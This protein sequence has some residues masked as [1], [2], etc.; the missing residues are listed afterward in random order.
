MSYIVEQEIKGNIYL[1]EVTSYWDKAMKQSRQKRKYIGRK[2]QNKKK[3]FL[4]DAE[5]I[6]KKYGNVFLLQQITQKLGL[7]KILEQ[8]FPDD[9][10]DILSLSFFSICNNSALYTYPLWLDEH[11]LPDAKKLHSPDVSALCQ[12][13]GRKQKSVY[14][15]FNLW[16]A[17][18]QS[19]S[20]V[21]FD[22]TSISSYANDIDFIEWGYNRDH[23][24]L[25]QLNIGLFCSEDT[26]LPIYYHIYPG[27][28][29][30]VSTLKNGL[31]YLHSFGLNDIMLILDRGFCSKKNILQMNECDSMT[32]IQPMTFSMKKVSEIIRT[33]RKKLK[34]I[35]SAIKFK[36]EI[37]H[38][39]STDFTLENEIFTAHLFYNEKA[40][41]D[42]RHNLLSMLFDIENTFTKDIF[43]TQKE[44]MDYRNENIPEKYQDFF[45][46]NRSKKSIERNDRKLK[47]YLLRSGYFIFLS[48]N[49]KLNK[50]SIL[51]H[52]R[53]RDIVEKMF[54]IEKN[55]MDSKRLRCHGEA[56]ANGR[57]FIKFIA[58]ITYSYIMHNMKDKQLFN[59]YS[60]KELLAILSK[61]RQTFING[62]Q[63]IS[64][65]SKAQR[66]I[67]NEFDI[68]P[69]MISEHSY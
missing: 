6:H 67:L 55:H 39:V 22:I 36:E 3:K 32:F 11:Q 13:I 8:V 30:D 54:D 43:E 48:N 37:L 7:D 21:Y 49:K 26:E 46:Y 65:V 41:I 66:E 23:E 18:C 4:K 53:K 57:I 27:S 45:K 9:F 50:Y 1:Y 16:T 28:I 5:I 34:D 61:I 56:S 52:Y 19:Y 63:I 20:S 59:K 42:Q 47:S 25:P 68:T 38:Y 31:K 29:S 12:L 62:E 17:K 64:E 60:V 33:N 24:Q 44:Y 40:E 14:D 51:Q 58:L 35:A 15:F 10:K 69:E 2:K